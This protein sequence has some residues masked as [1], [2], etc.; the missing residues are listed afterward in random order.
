MLH[1]VSGISNLQNRSCPR[2]GVLTGEAVTTDEV[3]KLVRQN[4]ALPVWDLPWA[5]G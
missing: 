1:A 5:H 2:A 3:N 4:R